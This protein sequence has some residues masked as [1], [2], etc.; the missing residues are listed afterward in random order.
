M[1]RFD[2]ESLGEHVTRRL[3]RR[4][5]RRSLLSK[6]GAALVAAPLFPLLPVQRA[7]AADKVNETD[8][9]RAAQTKDD[10]Q[11]NYWRYCGSDGFMCS[12]CGGGLHSCP[13]GSQASPTSW[14]GTCINPDDGRGYLIAYRDCC[15]ASACNQCFCE[16]TDHAMPIYRPQANNHIIW[17]FGTTSME[18][19]CSM[20]VLVGVAE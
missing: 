14:I 17:C 2:V 6:L 18:Y 19:H 3:A 5:S 12:C 11:C 13:P 7:R 9:S 16:G 20:S 10:T 8:F 15:G 1:K 4:T